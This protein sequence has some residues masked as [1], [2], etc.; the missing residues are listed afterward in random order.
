[1][2]M[3]VSHLN[4]NTYSTFRISL[5]IMKNN[6]VKSFFTI[7][8]LL[9]LAI[10]ITMHFPMVMEYLFGDVD[11]GSGGHHGG[12]IIDSFSHLGSE[13]FITFLVALLMF[14]LNYFI[15]NPL[16]KHKKLPLLNILLSV[17][18]TVGLV[19]ILNHLFFNL[20]N[21]FDSE[22]RSRGSQD[23]FIYRNFFV[24]GL[25]IGCVMIIRLIFQK[26][27]VQVENEALRREA[28]QSQFESLK[29]QLSPHF[30]F[31]S[32][33]ALKT[34][35]T[36]APSQAQNY[37][38]NLSKALR[39]TLQSN[40]KQL[41]TLKEEMD[42]TESYLFLIRMRFD[43]SLTVITEVDR[44]FYDFKIPPLTIQ[45]LVENAVKHNEISKRKPLTI[46]IRTTKTSGLVVTN[47]IQA[48][49]TEEEGTGIGLTN[50]SKQIQMLL[51]EDIIIRK[52]NNE[53][54]VEVPL[55]KP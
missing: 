39:Y 20:L 38:N 43:T 18:L 41:V 21:V 19:F 48:K 14:L 51:D 12:R 26:Q 9:S 28:L 23:Q 11:G 33:T 25:V 29:N 31:N 36:E 45:T 6:S 24:S 52:E 7:A 53:F 3:S 32:L 49:I 5:L 4:R 17:A 10:G 16:E 54:S 50:L 30:L 40:E 55:I 44:Y 34:L 15:L 42:F 22:P 35:I 27:W 47:S 46:S 13:L 8:F 2:I 1:M 37:V